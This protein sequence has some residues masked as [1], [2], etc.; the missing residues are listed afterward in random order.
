MFQPRLSPGT[1]DKGLGQ[2]T[3]SFAVSSTTLGN[4]VQPTIIW[5]NLN[6]LLQLQSRIVVVRELLP[7]LV[8]FIRLK[9]LMKTSQNAWLKCLHLQRLL[10]W[11]R[12]DNKAINQNDQCIIIQ[13]TSDSAP[14][15][16]LYTSTKSCITSVCPRPAA[17]WMGWP[18]SWKKNVCWWV[19]GSV[20]T[21]NYTFAIVSAGMLYFSTRSW[22]ISNWPATAA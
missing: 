6:L 21:N 17:K 10:H 1:P 9:T 12:L 5:L 2:N 16:M 14:G 7:L 8:I 3:M 22:I 20:D 4:V 11:P 19:H 15:S 18:D 13:L